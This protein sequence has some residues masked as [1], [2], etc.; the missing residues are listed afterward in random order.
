MD[1]NRKHRAA[2]EHATRMNHEGVIKLHLSG[3]QVDWSRL[4]TAVGYFHD[5]AG[6][7]FQKPCCGHEWAQL[8]RDTGR[9]SGTMSDSVREGFL[10]C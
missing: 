1:E 2:L 5:G 10:L 6:S 3:G 7:S 4:W 8:L 9:S